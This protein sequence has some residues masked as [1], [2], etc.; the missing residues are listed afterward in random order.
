MQESERESKAHVHLQCTNIYIDTTITRQHIL[1][2][3]VY[4]QRG[5]GRET[6][7]RV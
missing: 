2:Y 4:V 3:S 5:V 1:M 6:G 7:G